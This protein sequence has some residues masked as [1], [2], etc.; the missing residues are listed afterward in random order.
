M[1]RRVLQV[2]AILAIIIAWL[3]AAAVT[4]RTENERLESKAKIASEWC[5]RNGYR[6]DICVLV[7]FS[8]AS[9]KNRYFIYDLK[10]H[11]VVS[12]SPCAHGWGGRLSMDNIWRTKVSNVPGSKLS[13]V[14]KCRI[15]GEGKMYRR[16]MRCIRLEGLDASNSNISKRG[17]YIHDCFVQ[18]AIAPLPMIPGPSEGCFAVS[19]RAYNKTSGLLHENR[20]PILLWAFND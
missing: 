12:K 8:L 1:N 10:N 11:R 2:C 17:I 5:S 3:F 4:G 9:G 14:G 13:S 7:D 20:T 6:T 15:T 19:M 18:T 16:K